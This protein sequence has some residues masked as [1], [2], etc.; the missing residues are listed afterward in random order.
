MNDIGNIALDSILKEAVTANFYAKL[1]ALP[2]E[3]QLRNDFPPSSEHVRKMEKLFRWQKNREFT[4][5]LLRYG[6]VAVLVL[7][8]ATSV[9]FSVLMFN[10]QVRAVVHDTIVQF[11]EKFARVEFSEP[12]DTNRTAGSFVLLY[13]PDGYEQM[14]YEEH[15]DSLLIVYEGKNED[16]LIFSVNPNDT[17]AVD[18]EHRS[19][20]IESHSDIEFY[21]YESHDTDYFSDI[22]WTQDDF[23]FTLT[24]TLP[25][26]ELLKMALSSQ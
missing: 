20:R 23:M 2:S 12:D 1:E 13:I 15:G 8:V 3:E 11:F 4:R 7:C 14:S 26:D 9:L 10:P 25:V 21:I 5:S 6:K 22:I 19:Y 17:H 18:S 24:G 16:I